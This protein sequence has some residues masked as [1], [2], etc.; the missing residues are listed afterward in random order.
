[1]TG[2]AE[3]DVGTDEF[4]RGGFGDGGVDA[5]TSVGDVSR[6][7]FEGLFQL[8]FIQ[9]SAFRDVFRRER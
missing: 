3:G 9:C 8:V 1:M 7:V 2:F 4:G 6:E 5:G